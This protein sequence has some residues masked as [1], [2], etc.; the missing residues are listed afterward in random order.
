MAGSSTANAA[1]FYLDLSSPEAW[2]SA[3]RILALMPVPCEWVPVPMPFAGG[4]RCAEDEEIFTL[5]TRA[6]R[7]AARPL[8]GP[9]P[10]RL[11]ARPCAPR[12]YAKAGG[13]TVAFCLAAFRQAYA[14]GRALDDEQN[15][16]IAAAACEIHPR[17]LLK[18]LETRSIAAAPRRGDGAAPR[19][20]RALDARVLDRRRR[21]ARR[22]GARRARRHFRCIPRVRDR[23]E[24]DRRAARRS[25]C[26]PVRRAGL[27]RARVRGHALR[28][29]DH[30]HVVGRTDQR[31]QPRRRA[32]RPVAPVR[33]HAPARRATR[34][35]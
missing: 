9:V 11:D 35:S 24:A 30:L 34:A 3:E 12:T 10:V 23:H 4:F 2:L 32:V 18:A 31:R 19:A 7:A 16:L 1:A 14:G 26:R 33:G 8:A 13:K 25:P 27:R 22:R 21:P 15:V 6:A 29:P 28:L 17:A 5:E 20:R